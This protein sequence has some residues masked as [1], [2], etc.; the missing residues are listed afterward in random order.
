M[1]KGRLSRLL[2]VMGAIGLGVVIFSGARASARPAALP[3]RPV[4]SPGEELAAVR[5]TV[6]FNGTTV[7][8]AGFTVTR[9]STGTYIVIYTP[10]I[11]SSAGMPTVLVQPLGSG[12][13]AYVDS[14]TYVGFHVLTGG[15][16][17][18]FKFIAIGPH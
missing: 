4:L 7:S 12:G 14:E 11:F 5:G 6:K 15:A 10:G 13:T 17:R 18:S 9:P 3:H 16:D 1:N 8:G 2:L